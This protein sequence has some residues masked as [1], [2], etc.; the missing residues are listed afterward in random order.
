MPAASLANLRSLG[1]NN[2]RKVQP[3]EWARRLSFVRGFAQ[4]SQR[5]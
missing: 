2:H 4:V 3:A 1:R 5:Y